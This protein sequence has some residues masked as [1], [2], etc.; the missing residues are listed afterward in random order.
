VRADSSQRG[1]SCL[2]QKDPSLDPPSEK[3]IAI[4]MCSFL[5]LPFLDFHSSAG[6]HSH[7]VPIANF[8][9]YYS[10]K[11]GEYAVIVTHIGRHIWFSSKR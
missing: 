4:G 5:H 8:S 1:D 11:N 7:Q 6:M 2:N 10:G 9:T 3:A